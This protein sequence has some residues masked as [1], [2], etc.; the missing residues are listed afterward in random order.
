MLVVSVSSGSSFGV[1]MSAAYA[2]PK[3]SK[4]T[5]VSVDDSTLTECWLAMVDSEEDSVSIAVFCWKMGC[6]CLATPMMVKWILWIISLVNSLLACTSG[7]TIGGVIGQSR[8]SLRRTPNK[9][10]PM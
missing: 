8:G 4:G 10:S 7:C 6:C 3:I 1:D 5:S 9:F 2:S